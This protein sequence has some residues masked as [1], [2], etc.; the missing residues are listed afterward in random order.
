[1]VI[2]CEDATPVS[3]K[4]EARVHAVEQG[5]ALVATK[6]TAVFVRVN[7]TDTPW[8]GDDVATALAP[9]LAGVIVPKI[10]TVDQL[11]QVAAALDQAGHPTLGV[12]AGVET[13]LGVAD[14]R[15]LLRHPRVRAAYFGAEDFV[16]DM[17]GVRTSGNAEVSWARAQVA[18]AGR[19][20]DVGVIDQIV[21]DYSDTERYRRESQ[22]ARA[23]GY[24]GKLCIHPDQVAVALEAFSPSEDEI[25]HAQA[26]IEAYAEANAAGT[27]VIVVDGQ[28]VD[29]ALVAQARRLIAAVR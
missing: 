2:D 18:L 15:E 22:E 19:L 17:G 23:L 5:A 3:R 7:G 6:S 13:A 8:F 27:G 21:A 1:M 16:A 24:M 12:L 28:M 4:D 20:A 9:G 11:D 14:A 26:L 25:A 29:E 10:E